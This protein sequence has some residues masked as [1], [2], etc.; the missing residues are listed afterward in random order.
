[1]IRYSKW[2][3]NLQF[4]VYKTCFLQ[5]PNPKIVPKSVLL[6][7][8]F[9]SSPPLLAQQ[10]FKGMEGLFTEPKHYIINHTDEPPVID[11]NINEL[12]W[13]KTAWTD[14]FV[15]IEGSSKPVPIYPTRVKMLWDDSCLY[16]AAKITDP[17]V[18]ATLRNH[19]DIIF[20][21]NDFEVFI[22]PYNSTQPYFEIE[23]NA[24]NTIFDLLL[25]KPYRNGG[26]PIISWDVKGL[27]SATKIQ[28]TLNDPSDADSGWTV[29]M[30]IPFKSIIAGNMTMPPTPGALWRIN[31]SRVEWD[32]KI[33]DGKYIKLTDAA[34]KPL[35]E[36]NWVWSPQGVINM[37]YPERWGYLEF[38]GKLSDSISFTFP[39]K[40]KQK[41]Y[42][43]L[44]YYKQHLWH[45]KHYSYASS[46]ADLGIDSKVTIDGILNTLNLEATTSQFTASIVDA[47][48]KTA[49]SIDQE[50]VVKP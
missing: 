39:S 43:W 50:G 34:G 24:I 1:L 20:R 37:H 48:K 40:E 44:I 47:G 32:T 5:F 7:L 49:F 11:G 9:L 35:P 22:A 19:D 28:G 31:F 16:I 6:I 42:L 25:T 15:D 13:Q 38:S 18:W 21:D 33:V 14:E 12:E 17:N 3:L 41:Q 30:A 46:L 2:V 27:R 26:D 8:F 29:E 23:V 4:T 36:H 45:E 10:A